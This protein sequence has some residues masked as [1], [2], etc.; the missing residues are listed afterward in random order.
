MNLFHALTV[1]K[2]W[3]GSI[4]GNFV[5]SYLNYD[6]NNDHSQLFTFLNEDEEIVARIDPAETLMPAASGPGF[7]IVHDYVKDESVIIE[8]IQSIPFTIR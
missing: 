4:N 5:D 7:Y 3:V 2:A 8:L 6:I 1:E